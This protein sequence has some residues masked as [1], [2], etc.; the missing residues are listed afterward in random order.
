MHCGRAIVDFKVP[1]DRVKTPP[2]QAVELARLLRAGELT[3]LWVPDEG[4]EAGGEAL[5]RSEN[6]LTSGTIVC[7]L[8]TD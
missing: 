1:C 5:T 2:R 7:A 3:A 8:D 6:R 4:H